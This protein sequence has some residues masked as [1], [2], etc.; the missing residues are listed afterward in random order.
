[1]SDSG[2]LSQPATMLTGMTK[3]FG[4]LAEASVDSASA[5]E[6]K[7]ESNMNVDLF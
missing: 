3:Q 2:E 6:E 1:M 7:P 5:S 4:S